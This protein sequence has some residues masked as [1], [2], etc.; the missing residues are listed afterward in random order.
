MTNPELTALA[1]LRSG[2]SFAEAAESS[3]LTVEKVMVLWRAAQTSFPQAVTF[4]G[5]RK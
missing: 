3:G 5:S 4:G 1:I 2:R